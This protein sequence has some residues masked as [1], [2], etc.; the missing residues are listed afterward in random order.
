MTT[1][2]GGPVFPGEYVAVYGDDKQYSGMSLRDWFA[3][4][5]LA[6]FLA[7][8]HN[9]GVWSERNNDDAS[10]GAGADQTDIAECAYQYADAMLATRKDQPDAQA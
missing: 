2:D 3:G 5:A 4:Q 6:G 9:E 1:D 7:S 8:P 10:D